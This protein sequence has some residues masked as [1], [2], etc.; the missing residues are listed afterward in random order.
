[1]G[2]HG[3]YGTLTRRTMTHPALQQVPRRGRGGR[4][5]TMTGIHRIG[6]GRPLIVA[7][8]ASVGDHTPSGSLN[9]VTVASEGRWTAPVS[10]DLAS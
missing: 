9:Y 5:V 8:G 7:R 4:L 2:G 6:V 1:M 10:V 3:S